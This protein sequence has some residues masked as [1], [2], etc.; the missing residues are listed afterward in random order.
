MNMQPLWI[1][2][3]P[4]IAEEFFRHALTYM[5]LESSQLHEIEVWHLGSTPEAI[6]LTRNKAYLMRSLIRPLNSSKCNV[7][8]VDKSRALSEY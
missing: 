5:S 3:E 6:L 8:I 2:K 4:C 7:N 1:S